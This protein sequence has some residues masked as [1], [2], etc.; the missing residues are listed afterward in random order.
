MGKI[1]T[2]PPFHKR[3]VMKGYIHGQLCV[4]KVPGTKPQQWSIT[5]VATGMNVIIDLKIA[6]MKMAEV[7]E[8]ATKLL[9]R[10]TWYIESAGWGRYGDY[11]RHEAL[12]KV[13]KEVLE[14][15]GYKVD[16]RVYN[17][18]EKEVIRHMCSCGKIAKRYIR[19][20]DKERW[21]NKCLECE[22]YTKENE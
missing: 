1:N 3:H 4:H 21:K 22:P 13:L 10:D 12:Q 5:H 7:K 18:A 20:E 2:C 14:G 16:T 8:F 19:S 6:F 17:P 15:E 11:K 9:A